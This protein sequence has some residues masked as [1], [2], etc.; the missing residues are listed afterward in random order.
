M[1]M[2][3]KQFERTYDRRAI[4]DALSQTDSVNQAASLAGLPTQVFRSLMELYRV[5]HSD[6][7]QNDC[8]A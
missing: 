2:T 4:E 3:R 1:S 5:E 8:L 6:G 7:R